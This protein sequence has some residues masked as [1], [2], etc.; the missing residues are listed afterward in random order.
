MR[1]GTTPNASLDAGYQHAIASIMATMSYEKGRRD[2]IR[3]RE[4]HHLS[5]VRRWENIETGS[6]RHR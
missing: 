6:S 4:A 1:D 5:R 2:E 3:R